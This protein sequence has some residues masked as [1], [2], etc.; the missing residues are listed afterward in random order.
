MVINAFFFAKFQVAGTILETKT[1]RI[2]TF[3]L[4]APLYMIQYGL[5]GAEHAIGKSKFQS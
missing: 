3:L 4:G 5:C 2:M 1:Q